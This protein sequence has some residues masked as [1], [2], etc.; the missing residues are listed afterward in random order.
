MCL[1]DNIDTF[2]LEN[3]INKIIEGLKKVETLEIDTR[4]QLC[5]I[6]EIEGV[7]DLSAGGYVTLSRK[8]LVVVKDELYD[9]SLS[10]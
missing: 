4:E 9:I 2:E 6:P 3:L 5:K 10:H 8:K 1:M 7:L